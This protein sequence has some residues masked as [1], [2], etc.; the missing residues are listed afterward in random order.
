MDADAILV[1]GL[2]ANRWL[3]AP[4]A[5]RLRACGFAPL[6]FGYRGVHASPKDNAVRLGAFIGDRASSA[7]VHLVGHSLGG[8]IILHLLQDQPELVTG[9]VVLLGTPLA[10]S[11]SAARL[12]R[13]SWGRWALGHSVTAGLLGGA[14]PSAGLRETGMIAGTLGVGLGRLLGRFDEPGDGVVTVRETRSDALADHLSLPVNHTGLLFSPA[15]VRQI[16]L[17]LHSGRFAH[18]GD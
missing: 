13:H 14:P 7:T 5:R 16:C 15:V 1:H 10:G 8:L 3:M 17:F 18:G 2:W 4:L 11:R 6:R 9:R 12:D